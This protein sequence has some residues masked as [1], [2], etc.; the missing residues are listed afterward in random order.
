MMFDVTKQRIELSLFFDVQ[1]GNPNGDP[2][3]DNKPRMDPHDGHGLVTDVCIKRKVRDYLSDVFG[4]ELFINREAKS[5][6]QLLEEVAIATGTTEGKKAKKKKTTEKAPE[7]DEES[8][9]LKKTSAKSALDELTGRKIRA[10]ELCK[11]FVDVRLFGAMAETG[12]YPAGRVRGPLQFC[13][14]RSLSVVVPTKHQIARVAITKTEELEKNSTFGERWLVPYAAY[15]MDGTCTPSMARNTGM[16]TEDFMR[17]LEALLR[18][19]ARDRASARGIMGCRALILAVHETEDGR[20]HAGQVLSAIRTTRNH[21]APRSWADFG[22]VAISGTPL[23][24]GVTYYSVT[25][26]A[27]GPVLTHIGGS[28]ASA[29]SDE[30]NGSDAST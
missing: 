24:Q 29:V 7:T 12:D 3:A 26:S 21:P 18:V 25:D 11:R 19:W 13:F 17:V 30:S 23:P 14:A 20:A 2:R 9:E 6:N 5:L 27:S 22:D 10:A 4:C 8:A 16:S 1:E 15:R 28:L